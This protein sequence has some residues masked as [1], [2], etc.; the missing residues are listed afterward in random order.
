MP[1]Q[2]KLWEI[3]ESKDFAKRRDALGNVKRI[4]EALRGFYWIIARDPN[5]FPA[6]SEESRVRIAEI[7]PLLSDEGELISCMI[8]YRIEDE[9]GLELLWIQAYNVE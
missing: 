7:G 4:D 5:S 9:D 2:R 6:I 3:R 1:Q 8:L